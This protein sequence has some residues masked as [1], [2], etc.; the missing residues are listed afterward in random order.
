MKQELYIINLSRAGPGNFRRQRSKGYELLWMVVEALL[1]T[2]SLQVSSSLRCAI[3]R[4]FGAHI[5]R[6]VI[7]RPRV[8]VKFPWNLEIG[9]RCWIGEGVWF[10]NQDQIVIGHDT[11]VSQE[12]FITTGSHDA[13]STMDLI[14]KPVTIGRG[15]WLTT[16]CIVQQ[17]VTIGDNVLVTPGSVVHKSL[18]AGGIYAGNPVRRIKDRVM[19][20]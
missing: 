13:R 12:T 3:L 11:V 17:G 9:D 10:H 18:P 4:A 20:G 7:I 5:G 1:V 14:V 8:R 16:R 6:D 19:H 2:N 15:V